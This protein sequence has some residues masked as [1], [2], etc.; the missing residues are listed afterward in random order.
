M[1]SRVEIT[2]YQSLREASIT[3]GWFTA[4]TGPTGSGKSALFRALQMLA[5]N[6]RGTSYIS[7]GRKTCTVSARGSTPTPGTGWAV[8]LTRSSDRGGKNEYRVAREV[9]TAVRDGY[10]W[11]ACAYT[12]LNSQ[13]PSAASGALGLTELNFAGQ[14]DP[15]YL[16]SLPGTEIARRLGDLTNVSLVL[17]AAAEANRVRKQADRDLEEARERR[18]AL[19]EEA[20]EFAGIR[21]RRAACTAA[22]EALLAAQATAASLERLRALTGR[23]EAA[24][25]AAAAARA[26]AE[27]QAPP[28]LGRLE[29]LATRFNRLRELAGDLAAEE[30]EAARY[31]GL[32]ARA[33][34]D[35]E[36]AEQALH[37]ALA[38][39][40]QCPVCGQA[41]T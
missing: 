40:G 3:P 8:R 4:I 22:E 24:E 20:Q 12:K 1:L 16:L 6:A 5:R 13:V 28:S 30:A 37:A 10:G 29:E 25:R 31:A 2:S 9:P 15:P 19:M 26:E 14:H 32:A 38:A 36:A 39:A 18:D 27:L 35:G 21:E 17:G 34:A 41:V 7:R 33:Q 23:L 11:T